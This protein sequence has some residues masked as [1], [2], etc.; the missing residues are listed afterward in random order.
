MLLILP[1]I[2]CALA[3]RPVIVTKRPPIKTVAPATTTTAAAATTCAS[4][5]PTYGCLPLVN[6]QVWQNAML[7]QHNTYRARHGVGALTWNSNLAAS[8]L[9][10]AQYNSD[11]N[12]FVH[13]TNNPNGENIGYEYGY[14]SPTY[15]GWLWYDEITKYDYNNPGFS[16]ATGHF[17]QMVWAATTQLGCAFV[18]NQ[19]QG[20]ANY[21]YYYFACEY[22]IYGNV[23]GA[24]SSNVPTVVPNASP[25]PTQPPQYL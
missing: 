5:L 25:M 21:G 19:I 8:A 1:F 3:A 20:A 7:N 13:T 18:Q 4:P 9:A 2:A 24:Y 12:T 22:S 16:E 6:Q 14:N 11:H 23:A 10:N 15:L 17:T